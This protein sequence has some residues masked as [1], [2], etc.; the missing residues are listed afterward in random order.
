LEAKQNLIERNNVNP[1]LIIAHTTKGKGV[2]FMENRVEWHYHP[3]NEQQ[4]QD[5]IAQ[6]KIDYLL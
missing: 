5:A 3:M 4:Y 6:I 1:K 2:E